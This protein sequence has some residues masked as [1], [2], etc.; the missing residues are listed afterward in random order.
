MIREQV[1]Q[2]MPLVARF[3]GVSLLIAISLYIIFPFGAGHS[4]MLITLICQGVNNSPSLRS[5]TASNTMF[6]LADIDPKRM[7][8]ESLISL[9]F[10]DSG[11]VRVVLK[12][13]DVDENDQRFKNMSGLSYR[14]NSRSQW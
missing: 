1:F 6:T 13:T 11:R 14:N 9:S 4:F 8:T 7:K 10:S 2:L 12:T 5:P 3:T